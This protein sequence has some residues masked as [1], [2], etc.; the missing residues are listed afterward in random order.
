MFL[1]FLAAFCTIV[2][3][4]V[5][6]FYVFRKQIYAFLLKKFSQ[7]MHEFQ[8]NSRP[9]RIILIRHGQSQANVNLELYKTLPDNRI[10]LTE[11]GKFQAL[12][13]GKRIKDLIRNESIRFYVSPYK[14][15]RQT[16]NCILEHLKD[17]RHMTSYDGRV[18]EQEY[19]NLQSDMDTQFKEQKTVGEFFYR[20]R[21]GESG[22]DVFNRGK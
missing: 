10:G 19:G 18:R 16:Y 21:N 6:G 14:R 1:S 2:L 17:N 5:T 3:I 13:C 11:T 12:E 20:F 22:A 9:K 7:M 4:F 8:I 15:A